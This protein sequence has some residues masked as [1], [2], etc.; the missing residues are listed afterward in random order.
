LKSNLARLPNAIENA[1]KQREME[2]N[3]I[4]SAEELA[5]RNE[6]LVK[7]NRELDSFVYSVSHDLRAPLMSVLGLTSLA[8]SERDLDTL[9]RFNLMIE[10]SVIK[11]DTTLKDII[12]YARNARQDVRHEEI[13]FADMLYDTFRKL[14]FMPGFQKL[15]RRLSIEAGSPFYSDRY[16]LSV[17][18]NNLVSNAVKYADPA[19]TI[20]WLEI[21]ITNDEKA[22]T[23][24]FRDNGIGIKKE[25]VPRI[26]DMF[27][28]GTEKREGAGLGLY[29]V[30]E[31]V[32][33][34]NGKIDVESKFGEGTTFRIQVPNGAVAAKP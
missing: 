2:A 25:L 1:L 17:I 24:I 9:S 30:N 29:I 21:A 18:F 16:R 34:L 28:R 5:R 10:S 27:F 26:F 6:E 20:S 8:K 4:R 32:R 14:E 19:K 11:L 23:I 7:I 31:A 15:D 3:K 12:E 33:I 13:R 22:A